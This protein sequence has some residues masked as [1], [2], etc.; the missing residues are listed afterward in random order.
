MY[1]GTGTPYLN[2]VSPNRMFR[3]VNGLKFEEV[4]SAGGFGHIQKGHGV[5]FGDLDND[6]DQDIYAVMGGAFE[7]DNFTNT[8]FENPGFKNDWIALDLVGIKNNRDGIG[9][10]IHIT[11]KQKNGKTAVFYQTVST[12]G[13]FGASSLRVEMGLNQVQS[14]D[15]LKVI[16]QDGQIQS[17]NNVAPNQFYVVKENQAKLEPKSLS[18]STFAKSKQAHHHH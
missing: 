9:T 4:T 17:F 8:L 5:G 16:W 18:T 13:S 11:T 6:G 15:E 10:Q 7:G 2:S 12:G 14:I 3:N 1:V